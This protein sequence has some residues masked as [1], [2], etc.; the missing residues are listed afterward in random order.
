M[1]TGRVREEQERL[2]E[3][4]LGSGDQV[5]RIAIGL[6][7][8]AEEKGVIRRHRP[9]AEDG[10]VTFATRFDS[11]VVI[12]G[13]AKGTKPREGLNVH[14]NEKPGRQGKIDPAWLAGGGG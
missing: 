11:E 3:S 2:C 1:A 5:G 8:D 12:L 13:R 9:D 7:Q 14:K 4:L 6:D 10:A